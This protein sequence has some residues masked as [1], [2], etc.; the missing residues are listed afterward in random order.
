MRAT[1]ILALL[2]VSCDPPQGPS[3]APEQAE[4]ER[5]PQDRMEFVDRM[6]SIYYDVDGEL[7]LDAFYEKLER[8]PDENIVLFAGCAPEHWPQLAERGLPEELITRLQGIAPETCKP[9]P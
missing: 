9:S 2:L 5:V 6:V 8:A 7:P 3:S 1:L 4:P